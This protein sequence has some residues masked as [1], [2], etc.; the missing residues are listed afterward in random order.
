MPN[1]THAQIANTPQMEAWLA[2]LP[3]HHPAQHPH[4]NQQVYFEDADEMDQF[5]SNT[6]SDALE[7]FLDNLATLS[8]TNPLD[9]YQQP[10]GHREKS[11]M[12][13]LHTM[14]ME[15]SKPQTPQRDPE[16]I[17]REIMDAFKHPPV[18]GMSA[19]PSGLAGH[20]HSAAAAAAAS[21]YAS[22][23]PTP[24]DSRQLSAA[25]KH[26]LH[27]SAVGASVSVK[28]ELSS[29][30]EDDDDDMSP[31]ARKRRKLTKPLLTL[32]QKRL[33]HL[34]SEQRRRLLCKQAYERCLRLITNVE[35]YRNDLVSA[36]AMTSSKKKSKRKQIKDG[37]PNLL[38]H[39][40]LLKISG[41][42]I[43]IRGRNEQL[44]R[45]LENA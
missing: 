29:D 4:L 38:K 30:E 24:V 23:L 37:L 27:A 14:P 11:H 45:L 43:K 16:W 13:N 2:A 36:S 7:K 31:S 40:A 10:G 44:R 35:D 5:F 34:H 33:N 41:E 21:A 39:T 1:L 15:Q 25:K 18:P 3:Q 26:D 28:R 42:I 8:L 22:Q 17:K 12:F 20:G 9:L 6:E 32:E 19:V